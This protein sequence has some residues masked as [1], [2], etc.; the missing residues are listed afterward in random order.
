MHKKLHGGVVSFEAVSLETFRMSFK[1]KLS[2]CCVWL[3]KAGEQGGMPLCDVRWER[4]GSE[5]VSW[6]GSLRGEA[7]CFHGFSKSSAA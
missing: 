7:D 4:H 2:S 3:C 1:G 5:S 6:S